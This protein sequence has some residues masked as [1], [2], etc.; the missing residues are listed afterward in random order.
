MR[1]SGHMIA[2]GRCTDD[3]I[4]IWHTVLTL[5]HRKTNATGETPF[6]GE[7][8]MDLEGASRTRSKLLATIELLAT[9]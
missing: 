9:I 5:A 7:S 1:L 8:G 3:A 2:L 6:Q 4:H